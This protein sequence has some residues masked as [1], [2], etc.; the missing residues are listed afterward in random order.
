MNGKPLIFLDSAATTQK[1]RCVLDAM[2]HFLAEDYAPIHRSVYDMASH[3]S[4]AYEEV[5]HKV[6]KFIGVKD[7]REIIYTKGTT[8]GINLIVSSYGSFLQK[9]D[10]VI[11]TEMEHHA[12]IV[13]W[14]RLADEKGLILRIVPVLDNGILDMGTFQSMLNEKT[15]VVN[16]SHVSN[17]LGTINNISKISEMAHQV[18]AIVIVD[19]A[20]AAPHIPIQIEALGCDF[21]VFSGHKMYGPTGV[22][23]LWGR[24]ELLEKMPPFMCGGDMIDQVSFEKITYQP[25]PLRFEAGT[26]AIAE[27]IGLGATIDYLMSFDRLELIEREER[28]INSAISK[29]KNISGVKIL[30]EGNPRTGVISFTIDGHHPLDIATILGLKGIAVRSGHMCA[31]PL[32]KRFNLE[33]VIRI[34]IALYTTPADIAVFADAL[35]EANMLLKPE[36]SY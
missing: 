25:P 27:V 18:G 10:E 16:V 36:L 30:G 20:Q 7:T 24:Y 17:V 14:K 11:L 26:P 22:G 6:A 13:P 12:S 34:S 9:G 15:K 21:Y 28:L 23:I 29:L 4:T 35:A 5:R 19:G 31:Q 1:P 33:G 3:A 8:E 32:I 2:Y